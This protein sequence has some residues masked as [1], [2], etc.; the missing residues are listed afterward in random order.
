MKS[1]AYVLY[2]Y[3]SGDALDSD[4]DTCNVENDN[5]DADQDLEPT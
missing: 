3:R 5:D 4:D 2:S 1:F